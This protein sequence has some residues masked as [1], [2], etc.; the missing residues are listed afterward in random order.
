LYDLPGGAFPSKYPFPS[1]A[2]LAL[3]AALAGDKP[4]EQEDV[5]A[6][7]GSLTRRQAY[8]LLIFACRTAIL[9]A[10]RGDRS[11][12]RAGTYALVLDDDELD[13]RDVLVRLSIVEDCAKRVGGDLEA[14]MRDALPLASKH[15][16]ATIVNGYMSRPAHMRGLG[17]M[18]LAAL[19]RGDQ[20]TYERWP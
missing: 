20:L 4:P 6:V 5:I 10:R 1:E 14:V 3:L 9:G 19:G 16:H 7:R 17:V 15:R 2:E 8:D 18:G 13:H 12:L 11:V